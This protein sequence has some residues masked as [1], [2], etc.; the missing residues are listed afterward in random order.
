MTS[1]DYYLRPPHLRL[2]DRHFFALF[3]YAETQE[4]LPKLP[5]AEIPEPE[6]G[7][8]GLDDGEEDGGDEGGE[9]VGLDGEDGEDGEGSDAGGEVEIR[10][11]TDD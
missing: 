2:L 3:E 1:L 9:G 7:G 6:G 4:V 5:E 8:E 10:V 11:G